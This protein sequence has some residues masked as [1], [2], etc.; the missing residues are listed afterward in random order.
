MSVWWSHLLW[1]VGG[2]NESN[3]R[4]QRVVVN[5]GHGS[6]DGLCGGNPLWVVDC[7]NDINWH[8]VWE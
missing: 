6:Y 4:Q 5:G 1:V 3:G 7:F 8:G 2:L